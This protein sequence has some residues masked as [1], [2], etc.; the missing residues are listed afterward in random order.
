MELLVYALPKGETERYMEDLL[1]SNCRSQQDVKRVVSAAKA[2][3]WHS[4]RVATYNGEPPDFTKVL[5]I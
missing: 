1:A 2:D 4:F 5:N 3:G